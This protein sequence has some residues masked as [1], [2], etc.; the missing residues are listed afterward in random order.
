MGRAVKY[1]IITIVSVV[2][3]A[4]LAAASLAFWID[5]NIFKDDIEKL[6]AEQGLTLQLEGDLA[7]QVFPNI[8]IVIN[9]ASVAPENEAEMMRFDKAQLSVALM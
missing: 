8:Q 4:V 1:L 5:P 7:W 9:G 3:I 2:L 6:A